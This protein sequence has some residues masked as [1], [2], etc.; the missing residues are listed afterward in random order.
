MRTLI[1]I[2]L[3]TTLSAQKPLHIA[4]GASSMLTAYST[5]R[6][7]TDGQG[8]GPTMWAP[9]A[10]ISWYSTLTLIAADQSF[11][12]SH[13]IDLNIKP[14]LAPAASFLV[15]GALD[16]LRDVLLFHY[17]AFQAK[18]P[19]ANPAWWDPSV[20]WQ[21]KGGWGTFTD[22]ANH[23]LSQSHTW[24]VVTGAALS[25]GELR[26]KPVLLKLVVGASTHWIGKTLIWSLYDTP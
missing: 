24:L 14:V 9:V 23:F 22:D 10:Y 19:N 20:S 7:L 25:V 21:H 2:L 11:T 15:A 26:L 3:T 6:A 12:Q 17:A 13:K 18:H 5:V 1:L 4:I 8:F 16:G